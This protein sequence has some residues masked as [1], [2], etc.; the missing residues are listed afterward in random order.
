ML[1][2]KNR[3]LWIG[4]GVFCLA[5]AVWVVYLSLNNF[6]MV[7]DGY[8]QAGERLQPERISEIAFDELV[9]QCRREAKRAD[10]LRAVETES[11]LGKEDACLSWPAAVLEER[12]Q[13]VEKRLRSEWGRAW[14]K[15]MLF[16][17]FFGIVFLILPMLTLYL[18]LA[19]LLWLRRNLRIVK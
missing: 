2:Q 15:L 4:Y 9:D 7:H 3:T 8:R 17:L 10:K 19:F 13:A 18:V 11:F 5:Y 6:D 14:R 12:R 16:Y 1:R